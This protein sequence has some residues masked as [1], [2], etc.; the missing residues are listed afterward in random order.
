MGRGLVNVDE[1]VALAVV[2]QEPVDPR[3]LELL[4]GLEGHLGEHLVLRLRVRDPEHPVPVGERPARDLHPV[5]LPDQGTPPLQREVG[6]VSEACLARDLGEDLR[7]PLDARVAAFGQV[8]DD[9]VAVAEVALDDAPDG[10][11]REVDDPADLRVAH[12]HRTRGAIDPKPE[13]DDLPL[14]GHRGSMARDLHLR[15]LLRDGVALVLF[16]NPNHFVNSSGQGIAVLKDCWHSPNQLHLQLLPL[17]ATPS[18]T[19]VLR[20]VSETRWVVAGVLLKLLV[21][22]HTHPNPDETQPV[23]LHDTVPSNSSETLLGTS[24]HVVEYLQYSLLGTKT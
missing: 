21:S 15:H 1:L 13:R 12:D 24:Q 19:F 16:C 6:P 14:H 22:P 11:T 9:M 10:D 8:A 7:R 3:D 2:G 20:D 23:D 4:Q 5:L 17:T 18:S